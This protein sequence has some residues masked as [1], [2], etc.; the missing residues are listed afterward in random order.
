MLP[1]LSFATLRS[2]DDDARVTNTIRARLSG[3]ILCVPSV[4]PI[5]EREELIEALVVFCGWP[6]QLV[7][8]DD[9]PSDPGRLFLAT[10]QR[11]SPS[12]TPGSLWVIPCEPSRDPRS[13][14]LGG[15]W[16]ALRDAVCACFGARYANTPLRTALAWAS[17]VTDSPSTTL[18][19][20][21]GVL[22]AWLVDRNASSSTLFAAG[23][24]SVIEW[25]LRGVDPVVAQWAVAIGLGDDPGLVVDSSAA[26]L[27]REPA[28]HRAFD[29]GLVDLYDPSVKQQPDLRRSLDVLSRTDL[30]AP[31]TT[32]EAIERQLEPIVL[33]EIVR[34]FV[35]RQRSKVADPLGLVGP[36]PAGPVVTHTAAIDQACAI[37]DAESTVRTVVLRGVAGSGKTAVASHICARLAPDREAIWV[38]FANGPREAWA[39]VGYAMK[40]R[41][42]RDYDEQSDEG[43]ATPRWVQAVFDELRMR[44]AIVVIEDADTV[45]E[46]DLRHWIP[47]GAG[48]CHVLIQSERAQ[49]WLQRSREAIVIDVGPLDRAT[50]RALLIAKAPTREGE[51]ARGDADDAIERLA[52]HMGALALLGARIARS[53]A[54]I[55][56]LLEEKGDPIPSVVRD[57]IE[58]LDENERDVVDALAVCAHGA[59]PAALIEQILERPLDQRE[60]D[61]LEQR[62]MLTVRGNELALSAIIRVANERRL[63]KLPTKRERLA[64]KHA[65]AA[66]AVFDGSKDRAA[67]DAL[68][69]QLLKAHE[70]AALR[71]ESDDD[72]RVFLDL[73]RR[74]RKFVN[75]NRQASVRQAIAAFEAALGRSEFLRTQVA[76]R[77]LF[78]QEF[79]LALLLVEGPDSSDAQRRAVEL[80]RG[81]LATATERLQREDELQMEQALGVALSLSRIPAEQAEA[82]ERLRRVLDGTSRADDPVE[83]ARAATDL[84]HALSTHARYDRP[85]VIQILRGALG[86]I[87]STNS[88]LRKHV[89]TKLAFELASTE[90]SPEQQAEGMTM[91]EALV[92]S[93]SKNDTPDDWA[94]AR[95][96]LGAMRLRH[97]TRKT[98]TD[99]E[100]TIALLTES[101]EVFTEHRNPESWAAAHFWLAIAHLSRIAITNKITADQRTQFQ[102]HIEQATRGYRALG[103]EAGLKRALE[104]AEQ[105]QHV[106]SDET[107]NPSS[108][109]PTSQ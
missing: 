29:A 97:D 11:E 59:A 45:D 36:K 25:L 56:K 20:L 35:R 76:S 6:V 50:A 46:A 71:I 103:D 2:W 88:D 108:N 86:A 1:A 99:V 109:P 96:V 13:L 57:A 26:L 42:S 106:L 4:L 60:T 93:T 61:E 67:K 104:L 38:S 3:A 14:E 89:R 21:D 90:A 24:A 44:R 72:A 9:A 16:I 83:W 54:P 62:S 66:I 48:R 7:G 51:I 82:A 37:F 79:A 101:L 102:H 15:V 18:R 28:I 78:V 30:W 5:T 74:I 17:D 100:R 64:E 39:R 68:V 91:L 43:R 80:L 32:I 95:F 92:A 34:V 12:P 8:V 94:R 84:A 22:R 107:S 77:V 31:G 75:A 53:D 40:L 52:G 73:S 63:V 69:A 27:G 19:F 81:G 87:E 85:E 47:G 98:E 49:R 41:E 65:R 23:L 58:S 105:V 33:R 10:S 55:E 70:W